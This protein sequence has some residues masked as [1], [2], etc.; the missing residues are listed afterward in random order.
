MLHFAMEKIKTAHDT[1]ALAFIPAKGLSQA[2]KEKNLQLIN[3]KSLVLRAFEYSVNHPNIK[4]T[5]LSTESFKIVNECVPNQLSQ[6][7]FESIN[8]GN[9]IEVKSNVYIH[10]RLDKHVTGSS[11]TMDSILDFLAKAPHEIN[12]LS[13]MLLLQPTSPFRTISEFIDIDLLA[14]L[15]ECDSVISAKLFDSPHPDKAF[16]VKSNLALVYSDQTREKLSTPRQE[17]QRLYVFDG[18][19]YYSKLESLKSQKSFITTNTKVFIREGWTTLNIDNNEDLFL[20]SLIAAKEN[21]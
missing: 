13:H 8:P 3:G 21:I 1:K 9:S 14:R 19:Y 6:V 4:T 10:K 7:D 12:I 11:K 18:A 5:V 20:A 17:L 16:E 15:S 2:I